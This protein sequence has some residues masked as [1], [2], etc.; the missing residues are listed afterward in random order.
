MARL[1]RSSTVLETAR[2]RLSGL[3]TITPKPNFGPAL[4]LD[5]YEQEIDAFSTNLDNYNETLTLLDRL[6]NDLEATEAQLREKNRRMLAATE[7]HYGPD[8]N[9]YETAGGTRTS[10]GF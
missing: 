7:A 5:Q 2:Q 4:D 1:K 6:T 10:D 9:E 3:K 8:S